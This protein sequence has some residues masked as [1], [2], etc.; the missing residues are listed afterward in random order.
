MRAIRLLGRLFV[1]G[2]AGCGGDDEPAGQPESS[3]DGD[4]KQVFA[5]TCGGCHT[6]KAAGTSGSIGP[7]LDELKPDAAR[8]LAALKSGPGAMPE[9]LLSGDDAQS[10]A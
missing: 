10:V 7:D 6:L 4:P 3:G 2:L 5:S 8:V 9:N 1:L